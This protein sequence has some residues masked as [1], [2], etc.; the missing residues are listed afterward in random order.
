VIAQ[1][2]DGKPPARPG[3]KAVPPIYVGVWG[4][5]LEGGQ[6]RI[7]RN[8]ATDGVTGELAFP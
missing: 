8:P 6:P 7:D 3:V 2:A 1:F 5:L 4:G